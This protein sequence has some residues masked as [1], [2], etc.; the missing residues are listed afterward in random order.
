MSV[1]EPSVE[2]D[3]ATRILVRQLLGGIAQYERAVI[4]G[5]MMAGKA[6]KVARGG[7]GGGRPAYGLKA[8]GGQLVTNPDERDIIKSI[9]QLRETGASYRE[10]AN[11]LAR[12]GHLTRTGGSWNPIKSDELRS[13]PRRI[14]GN[15]SGL[16][17]PVEIVFAGTAVLAAVRA[18]GAGRV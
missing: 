8:S 2:G 18:I 3:D 9:E 5:R 7:Y 15:L 10:I 13:E 14:E 6:A 4:R 11:E 12:G 16:L 17:M 1:S